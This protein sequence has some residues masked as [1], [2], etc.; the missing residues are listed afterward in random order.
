MNSDL[1]KY[2]Y[3]QRLIIVKRKYREKIVLYKV[4]LLKSHGVLCTHKITDYD[5]YLLDILYETLFSI[6]EKKNIA[7]IVGMRISDLKAYARG[8]YSAIG[9]ITK[10]EIEDIKSIIPEIVNE[11]KY[12][13]FNIQDYFVFGSANRKTDKQLSEFLR[14]RKINYITYKFTPAKRENIYKDLAKNAGIYFP[15]EFTEQEIEQY[16]KIMLKEDNNDR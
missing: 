1:S 12:Y 4:E 8:L 6:G 14:N 9:F 15:P 11:Y 10:P 16:I 2:T 7:K 13:T 3:N 5:F